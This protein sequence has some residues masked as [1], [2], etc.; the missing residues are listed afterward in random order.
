[1]QYR[2]LGRTGIS[3]SEIGFG[4]WGIGGWGKRDDQEAIHTA[5]AYGDGHSETLIGQVVKGRRDKVVI[6]TKVPPKTFRWPVLPHEP[7]KNTFPNEWVIQ[8]TET[9]L[10]KLD[11]DY[12]DMQQLHSWSPAYTEQTEWFE[13]ME[14]LPAAIAHNVGIIVRVTLAP[15]GRRWQRSH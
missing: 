5:Y 15:T 8:C 10:R 4:S 9:S 14:L 1:M 2:K 6:A 11:T 3:I 7:V 13:A 12:V